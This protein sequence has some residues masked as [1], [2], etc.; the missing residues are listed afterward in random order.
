VK[1]ASREGGTARTLAVTAP[2]WLPNPLSNGYRPAST[3]TTPTD[4]RLLGSNED[5]DSVTKGQPPATCFATLAFKAG[6][7]IFAPDQGMGLVHIVRSG[8]VRLFKPLGE[9]RAINLGVLG[10]NTIFT[11][12]ADP[13]GLSSGSAAEAL[14]DSTI[15]VVTEDGLADLITRNPQLAP[16]VVR[17]MSR[18]LSEMQ[19]LAEQLMTRDTA[20]RLA[21]TLVAL[22]RELGRPAADGMVAITVPLTHQTLAGMIGSNRVTV[23]KK[24]LELQEMG[25]VRQFRREALLVDVDKL[26]A[27]AQPAAAPS[28]AI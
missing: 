17:G 3:A 11:Q 14:V 27:F 24:L 13:H 18:R 12:E 20:V 19:T 15:S 2:G 22:A 9:G 28:I 16:A 5:E 7:T 23:T 6:Q 21:T 4:R 10:P 25:A 26:I 8:C 1:F